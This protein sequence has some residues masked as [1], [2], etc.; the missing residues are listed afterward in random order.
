MKRK[1]QVRMPLP[2]KDDYILYEFLGL[3]TCYNCGAQTTLIYNN[4]HPFR[5]HAKYSWICEDCFK[6]IT[7][8]QVVFT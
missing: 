5:F 7:K 8:E 4:L 1:I 6:R 3:Q 2:T